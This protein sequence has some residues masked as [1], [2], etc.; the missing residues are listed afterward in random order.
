MSN[1]DQRISM[2]IAKRRLAT[3]WLLGAGFLFFLLLLQTLSGVYGAKVNEAWSWLLPTFMPI[4]SLIVGAMVKD[5]RLKGIKDA[6]VDHF[7]F[8]LSFYLS[9]A[10]LIAVIL[11]LIL[12][13]L[14]IQVPLDQ[15]K[16]SNLWLAPIQGLVCLALGAFFISKK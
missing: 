4:L 12:S 6:T 10:Y 11:T 14:F 13:Y 3:V 15:L 1:S 16:V 2:A 9:I 8:T 7:M 5:A